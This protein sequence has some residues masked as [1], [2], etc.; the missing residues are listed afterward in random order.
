VRHEPEVEQLETFGRQEFLTDR[1]DYRP[2]EHVTILAP[3]QNGKTTLIFELLDHLPKQKNPPMMLVMKP[4]D[5]VVTKGL[6][7]L[8]YKRVQ[9]WPPPPVTWK[10]PPGYAVWPKHTFDPEVDDEIMRPPM[11]AA[12]IWA[13]KRG[14]TVIVADETLGLTDDLKLG[15]EIR[16]IHTRGAGM[17]TGIIC[18]TQKPTHIGTWAYN[19]A[20][21]LFL[22]YDPDKKNRERF[23]EIGGVNP[24]TVKWYVERLA[25]HQWLYIR[26][27][28]RK[29][30]I[31]DA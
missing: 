16:S 26:R 22:G 17:G 19:N 23:A 28:G 7:A 2:G 10:K 15:S 27:R 29:L 21:H 8:G 11:R 30:C 3:T 12:L 1:W 9:T 5:P 4:R 20:A 18:A 24:D 25:E 13:Y 6:K 14:D 31:V